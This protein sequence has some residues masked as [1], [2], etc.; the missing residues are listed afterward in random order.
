MVIGGVFCWDLL[1]RE[2]LRAREDEVG[3]LVREEAGALMH[4]REERVGNSVR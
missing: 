1:R 3:L 2:G 4:L